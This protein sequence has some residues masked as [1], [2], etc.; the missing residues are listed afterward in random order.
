MKIS[1]SRKTFIFVNTIFL[2]LLTLSMMLPFVNIIAIS[3]SEGIAIDTGK[4]TFWPVLPTLENYQLVFSNSAILR[5]FGVSVYVTF[6]GT[7]INLLFTVLLAYSLSRKEFKFKKACSI[8]ILITF[9]FSAP[10]I[11][12][13]I[14]I[15]SLGL[16]DSLWAL[17]I[18][19]AISTFNYFV[20]ESFMEQ[21]PEE[22]IESARMD[23]AGELRT[24]VQIVF[25][26]A[27][28][29]LAT[30]GLFY[31]VTHW[32]SYMA[33]LMYIRSKAYYPLQVKLRE[34]IMEGNVDASS[35]DM[36]VLS[37]YGVKMTTIIVSII[38]IL[39][40]YPFIQKY[41]VSGMTLGGVKE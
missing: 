10:L 24:L 18:P 16:L 30:V 35:Q 15:K 1:K 32:N 2:S 19:S 37:S 5:S 14:L 23:G 33:A 39:A 27:K 38:P 12:T 26:L 7:L 21:V 31:A 3:F 13:Y 22:I 17:M 11:P 25:P 36:V 9:V 29:A 34:I 40:V 6:I 41:F 4:V 8:F 28:P 20:L